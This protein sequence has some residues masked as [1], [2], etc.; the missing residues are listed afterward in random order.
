MWVELLLSVLMIGLGVC[1]IIGINHVCYSLLPYVV[2]WWKL[3][4]QNCFCY[5]CLFQV[6][7]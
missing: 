3:F 4:V 5:M 2:N 7:S 6:P 1:L